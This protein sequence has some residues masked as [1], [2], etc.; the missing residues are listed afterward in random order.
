MVG[1]EGGRQTAAWEVVCV[2]GARACTASERRRRVRWSALAG[3]GWEDLGGPGKG[4]SGGL[5]ARE[6]SGQDLC[7]HSL[8]GGVEGATGKE[9]SCDGEVARGRPKTGA[10]RGEFTTRRVEGGARSD[11]GPPSWT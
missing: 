9:G 8:G 3:G 6:A 1:E 11:S 4:V 5:G 10:G 7:R 2:C